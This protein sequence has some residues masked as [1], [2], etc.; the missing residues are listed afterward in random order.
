MMK[1]VCLIFTIALLASSLIL[2]SCNGYKKEQSKWNEKTGTYSIPSNGLKYKTPTEVSSWQIADSKQLPP[3]IAFVGIDRIADVCVSII[4]PIPAAGG[5][6]KAQDYT[7]KELKNIVNIL[8]TQD[9][10]VS[11]EYDII[12]IRQSQFQNNFAWKFST[13]V[14]V[15]NQETIDT[16]SFAGYVFQGKDSPVVISVTSAGQPNSQILAKYTS[17]LTKI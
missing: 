13:S 5:Q 11:C 16:I 6:H 4:S 7:H 2:C 8:V 9:K 3:S 15:S 17:G 12:V 1:K 10:S 14:R